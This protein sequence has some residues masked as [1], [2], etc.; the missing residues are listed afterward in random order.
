MVA[1]SIGKG[2][3]QSKGEL[4]YFQYLVGEMELFLL[5]LLSTTFLYQLA[6]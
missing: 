2:Q 1:F 3:E 5:Y 6:S 4:D